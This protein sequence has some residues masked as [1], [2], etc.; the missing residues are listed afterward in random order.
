[1]SC[2]PR[3]I[4]I[5]ASSHNTGQ[6]RGYRLEMQA[7]AT[8]TRLREDHRDFDLRFDDLCNRARAGDWHEL[9]EVWS[10]F[11]QDLEAHLAFEERELFPLLER[12]L[13]APRL[14]KIGRD[15]SRVR[16]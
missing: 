2:A 9:D 14:L 16:A 1:M 7:R 8:T 15:L 11:A 12:R 5:A 3:P 6:R 10:R 13:P 4:W